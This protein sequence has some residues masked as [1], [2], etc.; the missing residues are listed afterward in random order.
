MPLF[1]YKA[2]DTKGKVVEDTVQAT[3]KK[4]AATI[5]A[6][7]NLQGAEVRP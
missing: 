1:S 7:N 5:L 4:D 2:L 6:A 3:T